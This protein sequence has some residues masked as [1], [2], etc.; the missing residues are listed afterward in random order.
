VFSIY[1][2]LIP[3]TKKK[4]GWGRKE[5]RKKKEGQTVEEKEKGRRKGNEKGEGEVEREKGMG[6]GR[7]GIE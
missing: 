2:G 4:R 1:L 6:K 5:G 7:E 3:N